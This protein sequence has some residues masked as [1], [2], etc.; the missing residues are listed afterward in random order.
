[1]LRILMMRLLKEKGILPP[2]AFSGAP[3]F[4]AGGFGFNLGGVAGQTVIVE[5]SSDLQA[6][7]AIS[8]NILTTAPIYFN[9]LASS[10]SPRRF[11]RFRLAQ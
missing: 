3:G 1:L 11:Y 7:N 4:Q 8:T 2:P 6:W 9:D 5:A 10:T